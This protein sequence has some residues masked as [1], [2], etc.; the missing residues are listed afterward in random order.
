MRTTATTLLLAAAAALSSSSAAP[1]HRPPTPYA[2]RTRQP[3]GTYRRAERSGC[4]LAPPGAPGTTVDL[5]LD[6]FDVPRVVKLHIPTNYNANVQ[7][8]LVL[9][10]T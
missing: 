6:G 5:N 3:R 1:T 2:N 7:I 8:P 9:G 4:G 10:S